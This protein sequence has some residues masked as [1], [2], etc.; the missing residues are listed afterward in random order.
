MSTDYTPA[1]Y[2]RAG[3]I[4][5]VHNLEVRIQP[6]S[7]GA[8][9]P[10]FGMQIAAFDDLLKQGKVELVRRAEP[11]WQAGDFG[12]DRKTREV[13]RFLPDGADDVKSW[14][15]CTTGE[16]HYRE[17]VAG[18]LDQF[19]LAPAASPFLDSKP[20]VCGAG[21]TPTIAGRTYPEVYC[22]LNAGHTGEHTMGRK[23]DHGR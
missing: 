16:W 18:K 10:T 23:G 8:Y 20:V 13:Y 2:V 14:L 3:D 15:S 22:T 17:D 11:D 6:S 21:F 1:D 12:V 7:G 4:V 9:L 5:N 19:F